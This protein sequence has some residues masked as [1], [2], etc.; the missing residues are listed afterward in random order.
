MRRRG[1]FSGSQADFASPNSA[2]RWAS[3][4]LSEYWRIFSVWQC[5][6]KVDALILNVE[7]KPPF[8]LFIAIFKLVWH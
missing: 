3:A 1:F 5:R 2:N 8:S 4:I 6:P 7:K